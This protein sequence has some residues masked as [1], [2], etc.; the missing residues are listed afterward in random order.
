MEN[1]A[2]DS[3]L[4]QTSKLIFA[5]TKKSKKLTEAKKIYLKL[6]LMIIKYEISP[7]F[8]F[9]K[10]FNTY[11]IILMNTANIFDLTFKS[12][13]H[14]TLDSTQFSYETVDLE[15]KISKM[16]DNYA[17]SLQ[18]SDEIVCIS[19]NSYSSR[20]DYNTEIEQ[21]RFDLIHFAKH[22]F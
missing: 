17:F 8:C 7:N 5:R 14:L 6:P 1:F 10:Q 4:L 15:A 19:G 3:K 16:I 18:V 13:S 22:Q 21:K 2:Y 12:F 9:K 11:K 20:F